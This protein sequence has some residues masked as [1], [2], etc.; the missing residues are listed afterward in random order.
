MELQGTLHH[1]GPI[2]PLKETFRKREFVVLYKEQP[3]SPYL[4]F[5]K[6]ECTQDKCDLLDRFTV[7]DKVKV[8]YN[9][10]GREWCAQ[11]GNIQYFT[12]L[13]AW[14]L[15]RTQLGAMPPVF[16][17]TPESALETIPF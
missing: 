6:M 12:N 10:R 4:E 17:T 11:D 2:I 15:E 1:I 5:I 7:G 9:L 13:Q 3:S 14:R 16:S 8:Q